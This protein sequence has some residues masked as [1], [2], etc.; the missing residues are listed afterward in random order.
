MNKNITS[1]IKEVIS[2]VKDVPEEYRKSSF[3]VLLN[4]SLI[5]TPPTQKT[6]FK[7]SPPKKSPNDNYLQTILDKN[8]DWASTGIKKLEGIL[9]YLKILSVVKNDF[10]VETLSASDIRII[11]VQKFREKKTINTV[12]MSLMKFVG[13]Y[14]D[15]IKAANGFQY[16]IVGS[17]EARLEESSR[18]KQ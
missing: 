16:R 13:K 5:Q 6:Q 14:V 4:Y 3:E 2:I 12:S 10:D 8:Y 1:L 11:L 18:S 9:Q 15:R 17:G 7:K